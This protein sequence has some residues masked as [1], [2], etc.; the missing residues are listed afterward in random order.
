MIAYTCWRCY[1]HVSGIF[2][3][4]HQ[5]R[6]EQSKLN[7]STQDD[8]ELSITTIS[9]IFEALS[10]PSYD[11][12]STQLQSVRDQW[13]SFSIIRTAIEDVILHI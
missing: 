12:A 9:V 5:Q 6:T 7:V 4:N 1:R 13:Q 10:P 2:R 3:N 11:I 8:N